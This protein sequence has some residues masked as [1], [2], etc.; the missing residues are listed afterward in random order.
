MLLKIK[1][2]RKR[3]QTLTQKTLRMLRGKPLD[4]P[5]FNKWKGWGCGC[6]NVVSGG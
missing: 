1:I 3:G 2:R 4:L 6:V 5:K